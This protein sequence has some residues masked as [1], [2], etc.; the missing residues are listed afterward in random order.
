MILYI[1]H[2]KACIAGAEP[3]AVL[4]HDDEW[5]IYAYI[6]LAFYRPKRLQCTTY[7]L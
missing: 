1:L 7:A 4:A 6:P 2:H 5:S 3:T